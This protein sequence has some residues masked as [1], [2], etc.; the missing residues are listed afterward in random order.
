[1]PLPIY[2]CPSDPCRM[3]NPFRANAD[4]ADLNQTNPP[5]TGFGIYAK[6][7]YPGVAG[8]NG[9]GPNTHNSGPFNGMFWINSNCRL[10]DVTDGSSNTLAVGERDGGDRP[11][12]PGLWIGADNLYFV[13]PVLGRCQD[14]P[15]YRLNGTAVWDGFGSVHVGG[16]FFLLADGAVRFVSENMDPRTYEALATKRGGEVLGEF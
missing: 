2:A 13:D 8:T 15:Q 3:N 10:A 5:A 9:G 12:R 6:L 11:R 16:A 7:N 14:T 4:P 1:M